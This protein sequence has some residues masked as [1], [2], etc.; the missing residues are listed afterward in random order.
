MYKLMKLK[1]LRDFKPK[2]FDP[3][4]R[5]TIISKRNTKI[6]IYKLVIVYLLSN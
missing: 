6:S 3:C 2:K 4:Q 5:I 1:A